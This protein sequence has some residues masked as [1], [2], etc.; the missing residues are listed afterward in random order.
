MIIFEEKN[1]RKKIHSKKKKKHQKKNCVITK[2]E[3]QARKMFKQITIVTINDVRIELAIGANQTK[4][5]AKFCG[6]EIAI[7]EVN[8]IAF[9]LFSN[10]I[11]EGII[12]SKTRPDFIVF[13]CDDDNNKQATSKVGI[14]PRFGFVHEPCSGIDRSYDKTNAFGYIGK[15]S[16]G[17]EEI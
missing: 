9:G 13:V 2:Q 1:N 5:E 8:T 15:I 10:K 16:A 12:I 14:E 4:T 7:G 11:E 17:S 3:M 6:K